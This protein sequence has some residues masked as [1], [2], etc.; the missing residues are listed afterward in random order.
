MHT[1]IFP[2]YVLLEHGIIGTEQ[3]PT[4]IQCWIPNTSTRRTL[5][6]WTS[7]YKEIRICK[8]L[9]QLLNYPDLTIVE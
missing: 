3:N 9:K 6:A 4:A 2:E 7:D 8:S 1:W 5:S